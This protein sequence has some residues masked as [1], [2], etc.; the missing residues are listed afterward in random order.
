MSRIVKGA[1]S[2]AQGTPANADAESGSDPGG[3]EPGDGGSALA[4]QRARVI[5]G[6]VYDA[7]SDAARI[8]ADAHADAERVREQARAEGRE[9][10]R[11]EVAATLVAAQKLAAQR[12]AGAEDELMTLG[13][14]IAE[15]ILRRQLDLE[16][17]RVTDIARGALEQARA[18]RD[19]VMRVH[20][21]DVSILERERPGLLARLSV[22]AQLLIRADESIARGGCV[23]DSDLGTVDARLEVQLAAIERA[24][25]EQSGR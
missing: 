3:G 21:D 10:G 22:S 6:S 2:D 15:R 14:R 17:E 18:Q 13:V 20:P 4:G 7:K 11:A 25:R 8:V 5:R 9:Q 12:V 19:L 1:P 16:P 24:L 23:I